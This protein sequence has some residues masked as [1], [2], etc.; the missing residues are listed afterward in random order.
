[1]AEARVWFLHDNNGRGDGGVIGRGRPRAL[2]TKW[3]GE[4][5]R[6]NAVPRAMRRDSRRDH[7]SAPQLRARPAPP[8]RVRAAQ[9]LER[10]GRAR[11]AALIPSSN[12]RSS[13][14]AGPRRAVPGAARAASIRSARWRSPLALLTNV[15]RALSHVSVG[16]RSSPIETWMLGSP[17]SARRRVG[18][19]GAHRGRRPR[20]A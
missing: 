11:G 10:G 2:L 4:G 8:G 3:C 7:G 6:S 9:G 20:T 1:M 12:I 17:S 19:R 15:W 13:A 18:R 5:A 16:S 14:R